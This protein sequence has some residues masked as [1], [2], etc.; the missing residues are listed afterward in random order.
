MF[1][2]NCVFQRNNSPN[3]K[4]AGGHKFTIF[5]MVKRNIGNRNLWVLLNFSNFTV[6]TI[7]YPND[8]L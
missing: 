5:W 3:F 2:K 6:S 1:S 7:F 8:Y 4:P